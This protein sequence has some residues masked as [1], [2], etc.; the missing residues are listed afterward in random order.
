MLWRAAA[1]T[2]CFITLLVPLGAAV[3]F[4]VSLL[5]RVLLDE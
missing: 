4:G 3:Y 1:V 5:L 2:L